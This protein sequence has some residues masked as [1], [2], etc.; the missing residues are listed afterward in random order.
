M[1]ADASDGV[2]WYFN[3]LLEQLAFDCTPGDGPYEQVTAAADAADVPDFGFATGD[4]AAAMSI[5]AL[6][7]I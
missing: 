3:G 6:V 4:R 2:D 7:R 5:S 1:L